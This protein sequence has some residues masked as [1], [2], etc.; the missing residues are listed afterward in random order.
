MADPVKRHIAFDLGAES[1]RAIVG[2]L[3]DGKLVFEELHRFP[4]Q[5]MAIRSTLRWNVYRFYEEML[6]ALKKYVA[7][8]GS[9]LESIGVDTWG[10]DFGLLDAQGELLELPYHYRDAR[11]AGTDRVLEEK[12]GNRQVYEITGTQFLICN[13]LNQ[14]IAAKRNG[15]RAAR[16]AEQM[17]FMADLLHYFLCGSMSSEYTVAS[18]SQM[19]DTRKKRWSDELFDTFGIPRTLQTPIVY[20]GDCIGTLADEIASQAGLDTGVK[21]IT[22]A[23]HDTASAA[24][25]V[26]TEGENWAYISTGTWCIAGLETGAPIIND[27]SCRLSISN[28]GGA[29]GKNLF[30]KNVMGLWIIQQCKKE[31]NRQDPDL[32]YAGIMH[33]A[34]KSRAVCRFY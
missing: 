24:T 29:F 14:L 26:P 27:E 17:L 4:T 8:Y 7:Q 11:T 5:G 31:W 10:I 21:I 1:G 2:W 15:D 20:A 34:E 16:E 28:S 22:P 3:E 9:K 32:D 12:F 18:I 23:V 19:M 6:A 13:T 25:A 30:L 33:D